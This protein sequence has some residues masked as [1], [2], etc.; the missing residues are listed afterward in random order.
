M[1]IAKDIDVNYQLA[2]MLNSHGVTMQ[3]GMRDIMR[4]YCNNL[5]LLTF[6]KSARKGKDAIDKDTS[7][8]FAALDSPEVL[9]FFNSEFGDGSYT[10]SGKLK[11]KKR[12]AKARKRLPG[13]EF[14]WQGNQSEIKQRHDM[15]RSRGKVTHFDDGV[16]KVGPW[17]FSRR[18]YVPKTALKKYRREKYKSVGKLKAGW[19]PASQYFATKTKGRNAAPAFVAKHAIKN[20][21]YKDLLTKDGNGIA[22]ATNKNHYASRPTR[23]FM[24][25]AQLKTN[26]YA[27]KAT[28]KQ[29]EKLVD[30]F[31]KL[32]PKARPR[33]Q[34]LKAA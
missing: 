22:S 25:S 20:G 17:E 5:M 27:E 9:A 32:Q 13:V 11:G 26:A 18:M 29:I 2:W 34:I 19:Y 3:F 6:P 33:T 24:T 16:I 10:K 8:L 15:R 1:E 30:R 4:V 31:N 12:Q 21:T 28:K 14:N 23:F 7:K